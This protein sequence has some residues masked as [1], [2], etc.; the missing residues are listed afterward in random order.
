MISSMKSEDRGLK[1]EDGAR[2]PKF[3]AI[4]NPPFSILV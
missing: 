3:F 2:R 4:L 1:M